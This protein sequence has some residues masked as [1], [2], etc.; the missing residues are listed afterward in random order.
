[1]FEVTLVGGNASLKAS[2]PTNCVNGRRFASPLER[3]LYDS[4]SIDA[5]G[6]P[7]RSPQ[8]EAKSVEQ[9]PSGELH[10]QE[11]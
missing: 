4:S 8:E 3:E 9:L 1:M 5:R 11:V 2:E 7:L 6:L 10:S